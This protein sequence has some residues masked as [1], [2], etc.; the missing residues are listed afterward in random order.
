MADFDGDSSGCDD[1]DPNDDLLEG[2]TPEQLKELSERVYALLLGEIRIEQ[3]RHGV[4]G[5][6]R[7]F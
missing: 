5:Y 2:L 7:I 3:E 4:A 1:H 6:G